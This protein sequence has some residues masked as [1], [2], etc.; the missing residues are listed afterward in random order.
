MLIIFNRF[1][2]FVIVMTQ[3][4]LT[5]EETSLCDCDEEI[6]TCLP[7][8]IHKP[9]EVCSFDQHT[10]ENDHDIFFKGCKW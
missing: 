10:Q 4:P 2:Q 5:R 8:E 6:E 7:E 3:E 9:I 1:K